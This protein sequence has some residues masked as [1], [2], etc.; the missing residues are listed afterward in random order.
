M[1]QQQIMSSGSLLAEHVAYAMDLKLG[2]GTRQAENQARGTYGVRHHDGS[3]CCKRL[4]GCV[5][6]CRIWLL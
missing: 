6:A 1:T 4:P 5:H 3:L 2:T